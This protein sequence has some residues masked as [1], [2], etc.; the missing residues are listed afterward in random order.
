[1]KGF[2]LGEQRNNLIKFVKQ[3]VYR[4]FRKAGV[5]AQAEPVKLKLQLPMFQ[6][7]EVL[8]CYSDDAQLQGSL[9]EVK[10]NKKQQ[11]EVTIPT[12]GGLLLVGK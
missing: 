5:N 3:L 2:S 10:L 11:I 7:K 9:K 8:D 1:M 12:N 4:E 6:P